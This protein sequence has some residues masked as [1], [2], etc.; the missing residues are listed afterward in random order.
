MFSDYLRAGR[1]R[2]GGEQEVRRMP[3]RSGV[4]WQHSFPAL[5]I[6]SA[7]TLPTAELLIILNQESDPFNCDG[8]KVTLELSRNSRRML[9]L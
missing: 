8:V 4:T 9:T 3:M 1:R 7:L 2:A 5:I 6:N